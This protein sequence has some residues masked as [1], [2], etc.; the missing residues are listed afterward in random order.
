M[1]TMTKEKITSKDAVIGIIGLGYVGVPT[2]VAKAQDG[3]RVIGFDVTVDKVMQLNNGHSYIQDVEEETLA[4]LVRS[5]QF[6][7][8]A[9]FSRLREVDV[10]MICVPTPIDEFK[11]PDLTFVEQAVQ[12]ISSHVT[13]GTVVILESTTYPGTTEEIVVPAFSSFEI[14]ENIFIA[15]SPERIDPG[16]ANYHFSNTPKVVGG[17]TE[18][19]TELAALAIGSHAVPVSSPRVAEMS[20]VFENA[21]RFVNIG[22][23]NET[24]QLCEQLG[25]DM[26]EVIEASNTKPYGF[27]PFQPGPGIG[28]HCIPVDPYYLTYKAKELNMR[29]RFIDLSGEVND[30]MAHYVRERIART[31]NT[32]QKAVNGSRVLILGV[33]YKKD[34]DDMRESP[35]LP[36]LSLLKEDGAELTIVDPHVSQFSLDGEA[37]STHML[38]KEILEQTDIAVIMTDHSAFDYELIASSAPL[39]LDTKNVLPKIE[40]A[41]DLV[42]L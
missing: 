11:N 31:L 36:V 34:I 24:A 12:T 39:V 13:A 6:Q 16:N 1:Y 9:D 10:V 38:S 30:N 35:V 4:E 37:I 28:G 41:K 23:V 3:Y 18:R 40:S 20:K 22:F 42:K 29:T 2:A 32:H 17:M 15:Y 19:C 27:M 26:W 7:A 14:G 21:F 5:G 8:T 33:A 25:I